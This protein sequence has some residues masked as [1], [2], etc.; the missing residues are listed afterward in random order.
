[1]APLAPERTGLVG[2]DQP[3]LWFFL[4][5][6]WPGGIE[7]SLNKPKAREPELE[8]LLEGP[9]TKGVYG[10]ALADF[11]VKLAP[12]IEYEWFLAIA[13]DPEERS[14][15]FLGSATIRYVEPSDALKTLL[16]ETSEDELQHVYAEKGYFY[17]AMNVLSKQ[18]EAQNPPAGS[19]PRKQRSALLKQVN[20]P[21][22]A[23]YDTI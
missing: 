12:D 22:A 7:F 15:D 14:A 20:L 6:P 2:V 19:L 13:L 23:K 10:I 18:I 16:A 1:M 4:S 9:F 21:I 17:D 8:I 5:D 3:I 11:D